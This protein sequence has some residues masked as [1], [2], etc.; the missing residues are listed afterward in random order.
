MDNSLPLSPLAEDDDAASLASSSSRPTR[1]RPPSAASSLART[2]LSASD[3]LSS[4]TTRASVQRHSSM[5]SRM[6]SSGVG[7]AGEPR[8]NGL[9]DTLFSKRP[10]DPLDEAVHDE[11]SLTVID[12]SGDMPDP[13][14]EI[15]V[16]RTGCCA[17]WSAADGYVLALGVVV[18]GAT[19]GATLV[20]DQLDG[21][22]IDP[23]LVFGSFQTLV[24]G[25]VVFVTYHGVQ[26]FQMHPNPLILFKCV[27]DILLALRFLLDPFL[28]DARVY[29]AGDRLS[30]SWLS[31]LTQ[32]LLFASDCWYFALIVDLYRS[33]TNPFTS[34]QANRRTFAL[35]VSLS[36]L[37]S[38]AVTVAVDA[39]HGFADGNYCWT[40]RG[41]AKERDFWKINVASWVL[42]YNWMIVFYLAGIAVL[43]LGVRRLRSGLRLTLETRREMLRNGAISIMSYTA[44]WTFAFFWYAVSF[45]ARTNFDDDGHMRPS[46][47]FRAYTY[48]L[49]GRGVVDFFVWFMINPPSRLRAEW[50]RFSGESVDTKFSAQLNTALQREL[51]LYTIEGMTAAVQLA[52][53]EFAEQLVQQTR[54]EHQPHQTE[55]QQSPSGDDRRDSNDEKRKFSILTVPGDASQPQANGAAAAGTATTTM[56]A[57]PVPVTTTVPEA[58]ARK[59]GRVSGQQSVRFTSYKAAVFAELRHACGVSTDAFLRS[60][61][62][63]TKPTISEG[64]SGAFLFFSGDKRFIVKSMAEGECRF[65]SVLAES[66]VEYLIRHPNSLI[67]KFYGCFKIT[68]YGKRFYFVV[69]ENLFDVMERGVPIHHRFDIKGSWVNRS[70]SRPRRG[71]KVKCRHCSMTF[72]YGAR[73]STIQCP[74]VVGPHEPNVVLKDNDLRTRMR[75][76]GDA[77][78]E[79]YEQL[80]ADSLFLRDHGIM[81]Y[82]LLLGV[83]NLEFWVDPPGND[84]ADDGHAQHPRR[85]TATSAVTAMSRL[86]ETTLSIEE[87]SDGGGGDDVGDLSMSMRRSDRSSQRTAYS[88]RSESSS[89]RH[90]VA[91]PSVRSMAPSM[92]SLQSSDEHDSYDQTGVAADGGGHGVEKLVE[93]PP[94]RSIRKSERVLGP[95]YY[96]IGIID[97]LQQWTTQKK[98]ERFWKVTVQR[99]DPDGLSAIDPVAYQARFEDKLREIIAIPKEYERQLRKL[100]RTRMQQQQQQPQQRS[101]SNA[102]TAAAVAASSLAVGGAGAMTLAELEP[103]AVVVNVDGAIERSS[104]SLP[105]T[106]DDVDFDDALDIEQSTLNPEPILMT[107]ASATSAATIRDSVRRV[108]SFGGRASSLSGPVMLAS[109]S[110][111]AHLS[112]RSNIV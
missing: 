23:G 43:V 38:G 62:S 31:G 49:A 19:L 18:V 96:Y 91:T 26:S 92:L 78:R 46:P 84:D 8:G 35:A 97:I 89:T 1:S 7:G 21:Y 11:F 86:R 61:A 41:D 14:A 54:D 16:P 75:I 100:R 90:A 71:A 68:L 65:L 29:V 45:S 59:K 51:I 87:P 66:Y 106:D 30:C 37:T 6:S 64:A 73:K 82:S 104:V 20:T 22:A 17:R 15:L 56:T 85:N 105:T 3:A 93:P 67:T 102:P 4:A 83:T 13:V 47:V 112:Q 95:G 10:A 27:V 57:S 111:T 77:G 108:S 110:S 74:N 53:Q 70:Y 32:C 36:A 60:F 109:T 2:Q 52:D 76:G 79:L 101:D 40:H 12:E 88:Q 33:L 94:R 24:L 9:R 103:A 5:F 81:D 34:V 55:Q 63:S 39:Y 44:Y 98:L 69:M 107:T 25:T 28:L 48:T 80:R 99:A 58:S 42:F 72:R 50:L